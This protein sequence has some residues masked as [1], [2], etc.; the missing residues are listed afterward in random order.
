MPRIVMVGDGAATAAGRQQ[1]TVFCVS[2]RSPS[3]MGC[4]GAGRRIRIR[5][6]LAAVRCMVAAQ[7]AS[8]AAGW[9]RTPAT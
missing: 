5:M 3:P 1:A 7:H 2:S 8:V 4:R 9:P 6:A